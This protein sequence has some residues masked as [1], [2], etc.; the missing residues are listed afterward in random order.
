MNVIHLAIYRGESFTYFGRSENAKRNIVVPIF[1]NLL[2]D[3]T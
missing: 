2:K 3:A 1:V